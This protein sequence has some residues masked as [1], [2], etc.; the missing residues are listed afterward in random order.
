MSAS[1]RHQVILGLITASVL[2]GCS[3]GG[4]S[5]PATAPR[6]T[7]T[8]TTIATTT[9][10]RPKPPPST[11]QLRA[12]LLTVDDFPTGWSVD[13]SDKN[14]STD[15]TPMCANGDAAPFLDN[16]KSGGVD[17]TFVQG[18]VAPLVVEGLGW[19]GAKAHQVY[20]AAMDAFA[21]CDGQTWDTTD[22]DGTKSTNS[23][24][25]LSF[26][27]YGDES[28]AWRLSFKQEGAL[29]SV[30]FV[31]VRKG[32]VFVVVGGVSITSIFASGQVDPST[33]DALTAKAVRKVNF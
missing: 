9:T 30:D 21:K 6:S 33:L 22:K 20:T 17:Q 7:K 23:L 10:T 5:H 31:F 16:S 12:A 18:S 13:T 26:T 3:G 8:P 14:D 19:G 15:D 1:M 27:K 11:A 4:S 28:S 24:N 29:G 2:V 32:E 25:R